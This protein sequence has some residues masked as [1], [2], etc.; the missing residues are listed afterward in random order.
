[1]F[2]SYLN[3]FCSNS[4][5]VLTA[6]FT[7]LYYLNPLTL[8]EHGSTLWVYQAITVNSPN[9]G[10]L[11]VFSLA[12][13]RDTSNCRRADTLPPLRTFV[14]FVLKVISYLCFY[15]YPIFNNVHSLDI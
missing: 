5:N 11:T 9:L 4:K 14:S 1:M 2:L 10:G 13:S 7:T 8:K 3:L 6:C 15:T 12:M